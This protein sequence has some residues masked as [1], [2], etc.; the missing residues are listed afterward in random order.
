MATKATPQFHQG[1]LDMAA[2]FGIPS[3]IRQVRTIWWNSCSFHFSKTRV[4]TPGQRHVPEA[5]WLC[6]EP[7]RHHPIR[8]W[9]EVFNASE[10]IGSGAAEGCLLFLS[11]AERLGNTGKQWGL[12]V[13]IDSATFFFKEFW[14]DI[15]SK[16]FHQEQ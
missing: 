10:V 1:R 3:S 14:P 9:K 15:N 11:R 6:V 2:I 5:D 7:C 8:F 16:L 4:T 12:D 13:G